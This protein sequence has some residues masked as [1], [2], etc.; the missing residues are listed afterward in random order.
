MSI[1][2]ARV[3][4]VV[5]HLPRFSEQLAKRFYGDG[6]ADCLNKFAGEHVFIQPLGEEWNLSLSCTFSTISRSKMAFD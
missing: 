4:V 6:A 2:R 3:A 5:F 1:R